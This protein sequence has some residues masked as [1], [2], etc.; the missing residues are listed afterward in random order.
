MSTGECDIRLIAG[1]EATVA[2]KGDMVTVH[3]VSGTD[4]RND[5][6]ECTAPL[7]NR[8]TPGFHFES[9]KG[10]SELVEAPASDND[11]QAVVR[12]RGEG[13]FLF[14][15][16]WQITAASLRDEQQAGPAGFV[17]NNAM[18]FKTRGRGEVRVGETRLALESIDVAVDL[19]GK[20]VVTFHAEDKR[21]L[22]F[23]GVV[24]QR[25]RDEWRAD[26]VCDGPEWH[27]QGPMMLTIDQA[28][29]RVTAAKLEA[30][31]GHDRMSL[32]WSYGKRVSPIK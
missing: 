26:V 7:P 13:R 25:R 10:D 1:G 31:D 32:T 8:D 27:V 11:Y 28:K 30:T 2:L 24:N 4:A 23:S 3:T 18:R 6:S 29:D 21:T 14:R 15:L 9:K 5:K 22:S 17:W 20:I 12:I 19:G 16:T